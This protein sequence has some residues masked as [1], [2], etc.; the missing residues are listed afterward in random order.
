MWTAGFYALRFLLKAGTARIA[1]E[2]SPPPFF[3][4]GTAIL[5]HMVRGFARKLGESAGDP[6]SEHLRVLP[7]S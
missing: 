3:F 6:L 5:R 7:P 1:N 2:E 4:F